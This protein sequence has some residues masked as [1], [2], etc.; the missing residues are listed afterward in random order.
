MIFTKLKL[1]SLFI[2][3]AGTLIFILVLQSGKI[4]RLTTEVS[5]AVK[6]AT[7]TSDSVTHYRNKAGIITARAQVL[8]LSLGLTQDL[9]SS[10]RLA[11][12]KQFEGVSKRLKN[13]EMATSTTAVLAASWRLHGRDTTIS[14]AINGRD[15]LETV[16]FYSYSDS[17]NSAV[18]IGDS[19]SLKIIVPIQSALFWQRPKKFL[20]IRYGRKKWVSDVASTNPFVIIKQ[21]EVIRVK[22]LK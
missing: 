22:K 15:T 21:H 13:L 18:L 11:F 17:L 20:G 7:A 9:V 10:Q 6:F 2:A 4:R 19:L 3:I 1:I 12:V 8:E 14:R 16:R 5:Q